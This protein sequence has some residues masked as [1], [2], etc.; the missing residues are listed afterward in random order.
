MA[1][2]NPLIL[3]INTVKNNKPTIVHVNVSIMCTP[4]SNINSHMIP[5]VTAKQ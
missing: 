2:D 4:V 5:P 3:T 1:N